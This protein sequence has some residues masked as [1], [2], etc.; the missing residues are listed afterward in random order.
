MELEL[1]VQLT[2]A[3][4]AL[5]SQLQPPIR[6]ALGSPH[7]VPNDSHD[8]RYPNHFQIFQEPAEFAGTQIH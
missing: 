2:S 7:D 4:H 5:T 3:I 1:D 6:D 8:I